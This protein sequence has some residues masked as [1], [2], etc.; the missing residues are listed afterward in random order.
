MNSIGVLSGLVYLNQL[1]TILETPELKV[2]EIPSDPIMHYVSTASL[3]VMNVGRNFL[4]ASHC[5]EGQEADVFDIKIIPYESS[6]GKKI[7]RKSRKSRKTRKGRKTRKIRKTMKT[8]KIRK[9]MK[10]MKTMKTKS[11][12]KATLK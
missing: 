10:T 11:K 2:F 3:Q 8:R 1:K 4:G 5:Q 12:N 6:G 9:T 7:R